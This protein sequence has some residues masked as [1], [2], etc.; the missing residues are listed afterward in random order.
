MSTLADVLGS[1]HLSMEITLKL[2][3]LLKVVTVGHKSFAATLRVWRV[4]TLRWAAETK[5]C[6]DFTI[7]ENAPTK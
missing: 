4:E 3:F 1:W 6:E 7:T 2:V 5:I